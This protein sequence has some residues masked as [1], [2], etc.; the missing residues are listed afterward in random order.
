M[1][2]QIFATI[3]LVLLT[4]ACATTTSPSHFDDTPMPM[5]LTYQPDRSVVIESPTV[6]AGQYVYRG[7]LEPGSLADLMRVRVET[8]G[9]RPVTRTSTASDGTWQVYEKDGNALEVHIYEKLWYTYL[10]VSVTETHPLAQVQAGADTPP[11]SL[12]TGGMEPRASGSSTAALDLG[13]PVVLENPVPA[14]PP[15]KKEDSSF[16]D[17]VKHFFTNLF[18]W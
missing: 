3:V 1:K 4:A 11:A 15:G 2:T 10:A 7:R 14:V 13:T 5:G 16:T 17:K 8:N 9:W 12:A 18:T 6:K